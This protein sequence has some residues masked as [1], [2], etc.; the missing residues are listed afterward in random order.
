VDVSNGYTSSRQR[1][2][3]NEA[4]VGLFRYVCG[5]NEVIPEY[6]SQ[7]WGGANDPLVW[8]KS[9]IY[10]GSRLLSTF[11]N[12]GSGETLE[13]HH[14]DRLGTKL[15]TQNTNANPNASFEQSTLPFGTA[16]DAESTGATNQRFTSY[17]RSIVAQLDYA[18]HQQIS[19]LLIRSG[20]MQ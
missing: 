5:G 7:T 2:V 12:N 14:P 18:K 6:Q 16:L 11:T 4:G 9:Y 10:A 15:V 17:D 3:K 20:W 13:F 1:L 8:K 19:L